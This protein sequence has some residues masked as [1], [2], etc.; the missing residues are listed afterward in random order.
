M[1]DR[2][3]ELAGYVSK[4]TYNFGA[5]SVV[6]SA[7]LVVLKSQMPDLKND[8]I[9]ALENTTHPNIGGQAMIDE[10]IDFVKATL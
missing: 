3:L 8:L 9:Q 10:A 1:E 6:M 7:L 2:L 5:Q 4:L